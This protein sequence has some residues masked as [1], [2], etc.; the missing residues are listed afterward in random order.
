MRGQ[1][2]NLIFIFTGLMVSLSFAMDANNIKTC[3]A[4]SYR[5]EQDYHS[6]NNRYTNSIEELAPVKSASTCQALE[7]ELIATT[8]NKF[9]IK[10]S[11][12]NESWTVDQTK[13]IKKL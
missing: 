2:M 9:L 7:L 3:L 6:K 5:F 13:T 8:K 10:A 11:Y 4:M 1:A 12:Q